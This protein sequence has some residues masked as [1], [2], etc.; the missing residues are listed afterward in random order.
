MW[1]KKQII[2]QRVW[3]WFNRSLD[4]LL[5]CRGGDSRRNIQ[6][7]VRLMRAYDRTF[8]RS[9]IH[10]SVCVCLNVLF[11]HWIN[12]TSFHWFFCDMCGAFIGH[13]IVMV[14]RWFRNFNFAKRRRK[15]IRSVISHWFFL[16]HI[17]AAC[18]KRPI[19]TAVQNSR[20]SSPYS[21]CKA[22]ISSFSDEQVW[23]CEIDS[24]PMSVSV[25]IVKGVL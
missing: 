7:N 22:V 8:V 23:V 12:W 4:I 1:A 5:I 20:H 19:A 14:G 21:N 13:E 11:T 3:P 6:M 9:L 24:E 10:S 25:L 15:K 18:V 16:C 2:N 17:G